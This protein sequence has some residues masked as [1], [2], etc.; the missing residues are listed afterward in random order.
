M[1]ERDNAVSLT[2]LSSYIFELC[3]DLTVF[4]GK[5]EVMTTIDEEAGQP[6]RKIRADAQRNEQ[7]LLAAATEAGEI[8]SD[9]DAYEIMYD[10]GNLCVGADNDPRYNARL[11]VELLGRDSHT[12]LEE[13]IESYHTFATTLTLS[14]SW[15]G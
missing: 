9:I 12:Q 11:M 10:I 7:A 4:E 15:V 14:T 3:V 1:Q 5:N 8:S 2:S 6:A 13:L